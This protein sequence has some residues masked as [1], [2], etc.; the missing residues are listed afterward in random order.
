M[1]KSVSSVLAGL[2]A[3][4]VL[5]TLLAS[6]AQAADQSIACSVSGTF[7]VSGTTVTGNQS[8]TGAIT[9]PANV[10][11]VNGWTF[12]GSKVT[13]VTF[14][15]GSQLTSIDDG[16]FWD[17]KLLTSIVFPSGLQRIGSQTFE[18]TKLKNISIPGTVNEIAGGA[19]RETALES[20]I[21]ESRSATSLDFG[22]EVFRETP[23]LGSITFKDT[24]QS[25]M[26]VFSGVL[27][28]DETWGW[29]TILNG[30][31]VS[32]PLANT[33]P[34][35]L[36][37]YPTL[38]DGV[39]FIPCS[40]GGT[41]KIINGVVVKAT[42][43]CAGEITIPADVTEISPGYNATFADRNITKVTF[44]QGTQ[45][46]SIGGGAFRGTKFSTI[47][48]PGSVRIIHGSAFADSSLE[49]ITFDNGDDI[50]NGDF[51]GNY[52]SFSRW[53]FDGLTKLNSITFMRAVDLDRLPR[54]T[55]N[56]DY[57]HV[58][59]ST[60]PGGQVI[61]SYPHSVAAGTTFYNN[62]VPVVITEIPCSL[63]GSFT[64]RDNLLSAAT[65][66]CAGE[67][68]IPAYV[69]GMNEFVFNDR[70]LTSVSFETGS[71]LKGISRSAFAHTNISSLVLPPDLE[72]ISYN[73]FFGLK[74]TSIVI[75]GKVRVLADGA[76]ANTSLESVVFAA[77]PDRQIYFYGSIFPNNSKLRSFTFEGP[78]YIDPSNFR[79]NRAA[80]NWLGWSATLGGTIVPFAHLKDNSG[81]ITLF[82]NSAPQ[83][84][85][86]IYDSKGGTPVEPG[87]VVGGQIEFP[88]P[89][90]RVGYSFDAWYLGGDPITLWEGEGDVTLSANWIPNRYAVNLDSKGGSAV[91][92]ASYVTD[93]AI[94]SAPTAPTRDDYAFLG[95][96]AT[97]GGTVLTYPYSPGLME[98]ITLYAKWRKMSPEITAG[99]TPNSQV[100]TMPAGLTDA[101]IPATASLPR[102][103][104]VL[105]VM[106]GDVVATIAPI[107]N[108][109]TPTKTP[110]IVSG[111]TKV[112]DINISGVTGN[113]TVC[114]DGGPTDELYHYTGGAWVK[115]PE[116]SYANGQ[117]CGV[118]SSFSP[119]TAATPAPFKPR[120]GGSPAISG[121]ARQNTLL[122]S[123][124]GTWSALPAATTSAQWYRCDKSVAARKATITDA[125]KCLKITGAT[126]SSYKVV[127]ADQGKHL[128]VLTQA[129][130]KMGSTFST[131]KSVLVPKATKPALKSIPKISGTAAK[132]KVV[133]LGAGTWSANPTPT[134][135]MQWYR[136]DK[137]VIAG[138]SE[139][140]KSMDCVKISG[141][142]KA[143]YKIT[144]A[145]QAKYLTALV[146]GKNSQ[147]ILAKSAKSVKIPGTKPARKSSP[148]ISGSANAGDTLRATDGTWS[149]IP[150]ADTSVQ[151]YRCSNA[152]SA[153]QD[154]FKKSSN[155]VKISGATSSRYTVKLADQGK[156]L[157]VLVTAKNE[158]GKATSTAKSIYVKVPVV[159]P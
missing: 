21:F 83:T 92:A 111:S 94:T 118:T 15:T 55:Q 89:P 44:A 152:V 104:F 68:T 124:T 32:F 141:A 136:C 108:P 126:K 69:E 82:A 38:R 157:S 60:S 36:T 66:N 43:D 29:S 125:M 63:G 116:R 47:S 28:Q 122:T 77:R 154:S 70:D 22:G 123:T 134:T 135:T 156:H 103:R 93:G 127:L 145:D 76:F 96:S 79:I 75:P 51:S 155:C 14:G 101:S 24:N 3:L 67:I 107:A 84:Y 158:E 129:K 57:R 121:N 90:T 61:P 105:P 35:D 113:V 112:V 81:T 34:G 40:L 144:V 48:I 54:I 146:T 133:T 102:I 100:A 16:A 115:L 18:W 64:T 74:A 58:G 148:K 137:P 99:T 7:T 88:T 109:A 31:L 59:W 97:D 33:N 52:N 85:N 120:L 30:P 130:N 20:V 46:T 27:F 87:L 41:F 10:T 23:N 72:E 150:E 6:P 91:P 39:R 153:G 119:F 71:K 56:A 17:S 45:L 147:G 138:L 80:W 159:T 19:F 49:S 53:A 95:W 73:A 50:S 128:T 2:I 114:L 86:A 62:E 13:S 4:L 106:A 149:G 1:K 12:A 5:P 140:K 117:V 9:I 98:D 26:E 151:W 139:F 8:C 131:A 78:I 25:K 143:K 37:L 132:G 142:T 65:E 110:F 42:P 11:H